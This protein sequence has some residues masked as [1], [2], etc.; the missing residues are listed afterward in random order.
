MGTI[1]FKT[2][3]VITLGVKPFGSDTEDAD[4]LYE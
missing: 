4:I 2:G 1:N 3:D